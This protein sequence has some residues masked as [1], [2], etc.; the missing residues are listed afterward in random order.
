MG[1]KN[2]ERETIKMTFL[3]TTTKGEKLSKQSSGCRQ[4]R[5]S[6]FEEK[7]KKAP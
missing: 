3:H 6:R 2:E 4:K 7:E 5:F 1:S